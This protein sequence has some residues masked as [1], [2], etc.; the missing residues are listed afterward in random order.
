MKK[1]PLKNSGAVDIHLQPLEFGEGDTYSDGNV[2]FSLYIADKA[3]RLVRHRAP[4]NHDKQ[5]EPEVRGSLD[6]VL[7][8]DGAEKRVFRYAAINEYSWL[9]LSL[10]EFR[11]LNRDERRKPCVL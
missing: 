10:C 11:N 5:E 6:E 7:D 2:G 9:A 8:A 3:H 4:V 1:A